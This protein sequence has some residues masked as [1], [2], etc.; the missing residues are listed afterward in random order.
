MLFWELYKTVFYLKAL[1]FYKLNSGIRN[2]ST[3][4]SFFQRW[5]KLSAAKSGKSLLGPQAFL[6][7]KLI[8]IDKKYTT[9]NIIFTESNIV[10]LFGDDDNYFDTLDTWLN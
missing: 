6:K 9:L 5:L 2:K 7:N 10:V 8:S 3:Q 4:F 1:Q